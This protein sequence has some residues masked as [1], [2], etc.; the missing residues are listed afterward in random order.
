MEV[1]VDPNFFDVEKQVEG[2]KWNLVDFY[3]ILV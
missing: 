2:N 1:Q 3:I